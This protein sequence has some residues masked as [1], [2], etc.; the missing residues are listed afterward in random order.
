MIKLNC[1]W[2]GEQIEIETAAFHTHCFTLI[3]NHCN[4]ALRR[5]INR[6]EI[7]VERATPLEFATLYEKRLQEWWSDDS[8]EPVAC[9][10]CEF[11][12]QEFSVALQSS[13]DCRWILIQQVG[14]DESELL[15]Q[16]FQEVLNHF[17]GQSDEDQLEDDS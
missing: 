4:Y 16:F 7:P 9:G 8:I 1:H 11:L 10:V 6:S 2:C 13:G 15:N 17:K 3:C 5:S 14:P 12:E